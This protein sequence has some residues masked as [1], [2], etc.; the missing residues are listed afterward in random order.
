MRTPSRRATARSRVIGRIVSRA[1]VTRTCGVAPARR[2][3]NPAPACLVE[4]F[5]ERRR[6]VRR[7]EH[8]RLAVGGPH[9]NDAFERVPG[10]NRESLGQLA[11]GR[12]WDAL[13]N[14]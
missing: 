5:G 6:Q 8:Q 9:A 11:T 4:A 1:C 13:E 10:G 14:E 2:R 3:P 12:D 7:L